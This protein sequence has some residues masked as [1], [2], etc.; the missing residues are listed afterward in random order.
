MEERQRER[1]IRLRE[2]E[3]NSTANS[4]TSLGSYS[5]AQNVKFPAMRRFVDRTEDIDVSL[6]A[7][8]RYCEEAGVDKG[9]Y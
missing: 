4:A 2:L 9:K 5:S 3:I 7:F 1:D 6:E 8:E